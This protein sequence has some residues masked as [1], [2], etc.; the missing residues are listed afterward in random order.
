MA[1]SLTQLKAKATAKLQK[2]KSSLH[3]T[4]VADKKSNA[5]GEPQAAAELHNMEEQGANPEPETKVELKATAEEQ[6]TTSEHDHTGKDGGKLT[7]SASSQESKKQE[8]KAKREARREV[9]KAKWAARRASFKPKAKKVGRDTLT[10]VE[11]V[12]RIIDDLCP[13]IIVAP[14]SFGRKKWW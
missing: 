3:K 5:T 12:V 9:R 14:A 7:P 1:G 6:G 4:K 10:A 11:M 13:H 8:K 2:I